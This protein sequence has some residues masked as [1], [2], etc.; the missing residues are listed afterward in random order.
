M[1]RV[2]NNLHFMKKITIPCNFG[3]QRI[4]TPVY[5]GQPEKEHHPIQFQAQ[6][7]ASERGGKV[8]EEVMDSLQKIKDIADKNGVPF[9]EL[10]VYAVT[11]AA[12]T[13]KTTGQLSDNISPS[14]TMEKRTVRDEQNTPNEEEPSVTDSS[15]STESEAPSEQQSPPSE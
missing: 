4:N 15:S 10:C 2:I 13:G 6:W 12:D 11:T 9:E 7:L 5:V 8:P 3:G 1:Y 14:A